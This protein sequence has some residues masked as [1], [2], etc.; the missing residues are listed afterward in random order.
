VPYLFLILLF[1]GTACARTFTVGTYNLEM[2]IDAP[3]N[4]VLPKTESS[5]KIVRQSIRAL[6]ADILAL[7]EIGSTNT[8]LELRSALR[9]EG[10][11][12]EY[13][14]WM[15]GRDTNL[16]LAFLSKLPIVAR[17]H[18]TNEAFLY[19]GKRHFVSRGFAQIDVEPEP[20]FRLTLLSA[21]LKSKRSVAEA[22][23]EALREEEA[24]GLRERVDQYLASHP[25]GNLVVLGDLNDFVSSRAI[26]TIIGRGKTA[27][28]DPRP[29][30]RNG[31]AD[32]NSN[33]RFL[34][35]RI[36]WTHYFGRDET[37]SRLD[38]ILLS[39]SLRG[40]FDPA[41]SFIP[42]IPNWGTGSDHRPIVI[43]LKI[44]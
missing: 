35:R 8:L 19:A 11:A 41:A 15:Q 10:L 39:Q 33:P 1:C 26:H 7:E 16:H 4:D 43:G 28:F 29:A 31:D 36:I 3:F 27:L 14:D 32:S 40:R 23:E 24:Q 9:N 37:Y 21:H 2:Y 22:D 42:Q 18:Y 12:Y 34:P 44:D 13:W 6:N 30:E 17:T 5:K 38:Y 25:R 20:G